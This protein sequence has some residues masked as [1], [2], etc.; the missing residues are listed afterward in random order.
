MVPFLL[1]G[2]VPAN[3]AVAAMIVMTPIPANFLSDF[4]AFLLV[5]DSAGI[6]G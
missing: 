1:P 6:A 2:I 5:N 4:I 3:V